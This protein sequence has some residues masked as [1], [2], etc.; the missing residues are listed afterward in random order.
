MAVALQLVAKLISFAAESARQQ[1]GKWLK[2]TFLVI[3]Q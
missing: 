3:Y 2:N 1:N